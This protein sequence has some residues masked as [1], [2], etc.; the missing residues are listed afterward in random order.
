[1]TNTIIVT[2]LTTAAAAALLAQNP[3]PT[4]PPATPPQ[5][6]S[7]VV[8]TK[9]TGAPGLPPKFAVPEF[10]PLTNDAATQE[11]AKIISQVLWDDLSF[12][13]EF[14]LISRDTYKSIPRP[15]SL[16]DVPVARWKELG[17]DAVIAGAVRRDGNNIV[18]QFRL[19]EVNS[20]R[21]AMGREYSGRADNPRFFAHTIADEIHKEQV[22]LRGVARTKLAFVST[23]DGERI[24]GP[25]GSR[26]IQNV[27]MSDY[28]GANQRRI[29]VAKTLELGP[30]WSPDARSIAY[31]SYSTGFPDIIVADIYAARNSR[32]ARG[33]DRIHNLLA[34]WSPDGGKLAFM[35]NRDGNPE[36]YVVNKDG[37]GL[38]RLTNHPENDVT[39]TWSPTGQ[40]IAFTSNRTG[41]PQIWIMNADGSGQ[42]QITRETWCDRPTWSPAPYNE[43]AYASQAGGGYDIKIFD[44]ANRNTKSLTNGEGSNESPAFSPSGRHLAFTSSRAGK[45]QIFIVGRDGE[46][47]RQITKAGENR[48]PNWSN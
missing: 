4:Q 7:D 45:Y 10:I 16:N 40:Q 21:S 37:S 46:G 38:R 20:G 23:R 18:V 28:D 27:Y 25:T 33:S 11:A 9:I 26:D 34:V 44:F 12:E 42:Q 30:V 8:I 24:K 1:M 15:A 35:S 43:I 48:Y 47:L 6:Q 31:T 29:S 32:P 13:R 5:Q 41:R 39:P 17:A 22:N 3:P 36:I 14:Y 2:I 19:I